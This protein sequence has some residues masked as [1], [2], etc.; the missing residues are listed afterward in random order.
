[1]TEICTPNIHT[2][3]LDGN[4]HSFAELGKN[5]LDSVHANS[6]GLGLEGS[7]EY[8]SFFVTFRGQVIT[9]YVKCSFTGLNSPS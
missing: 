6:P 2:A 9:R 4:R 7:A 8:V 3:S 1:M 5:N